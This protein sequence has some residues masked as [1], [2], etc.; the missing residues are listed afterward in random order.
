MDCGA[1]HRARL[2]PCL[3]SVAATV[4]VI[5]LAGPA[6][7][8]Q[9]G[10]SGGSSA[11][12]NSPVAEQGTAPQQPGSAETAKL[13]PTTTEIP[14]VAGQ[15]GGA[16][17]ALSAPQNSSTN[18][19]GEQAA[20]QAGPPIES[21]QEFVDEG[22][23]EGQE[24]ALPLGMVVRQDWRQL[25]NG[26]PVEGLLVVAVKPGSP[27]YQAGLR[28]YSNGVH[29]VLTGTA[30]AA[31]MVFPPAIFLIPVLDGTHIG[32][33]YDLIIGIDGSRVTSLLDVQQRM[34]YLEPGEIVYLSV[35]QDGARKQI[36]VQLP[37]NFTTSANQP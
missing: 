30:V 35:V 7:M 10:G 3:L 2:L 37:P 6:A 29:S 9:D 23:A 14:S 17:P 1:W 8:A 21:L 27:A 16:E 28:A 20:S 33:R 15:S 25:K 32:E 22:A 24:D 19:G 5:A 18:N 34:R 11:A 31:A 13:P 36:P 4:A 12:T 26:H